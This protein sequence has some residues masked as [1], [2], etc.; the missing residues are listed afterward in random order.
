MCV[1]EAASALDL[2]RVHPFNKLSKCS[3]YVSGQFVIAAG[4]F[5]ELCRKPWCNRVN[6]WP[7]TPCVFMLAD[8]EQIRSQT[9]LPCSAVAAGAPEDWNKPSVLLPV[10]LIHAFVWRVQPQP[11]PTSI[12]F[13]SI[14]FKTH[15]LQDHQ[16]VAEIKLL[17]G[18]KRHHTDCCGDIS[19]KAVVAPHLNTT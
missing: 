17:S 7:R 6:L 15:F 19:R 3:S 13:K 16:F 5:P 14:R 4:P 8:Y 2:S 10:M 12:P 11:A 9:T 18:L 1:W